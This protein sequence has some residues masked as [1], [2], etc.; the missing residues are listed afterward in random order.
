MND[1]IEKA[2]ELIKKSQFTIA[3][4]GAGISV[5]SGIPDFR[6]AG[7]LWEKYDPALYASIDSFKRKP[8][9]VW[10]MLFEMVD[11]MENAKPNPAHLALA[12]LEQLGYLSSIITQNI[13]NLH[14]AAGSKHVI[15][16]HGNA[17]RLECLSCG[18]VYEKPE[19]MPENV[20]IPRCAACDAV[21]K[22]TVI[23]FGEMIPY[24]AMSESSRL[25]DRAELVLVVGT[26]AIVYPAAGIPLQAKQNNATVIE[27][28]LEPTALTGYI[29]DLFIQGPAGETLNRVL[30]MLEKG[31][32]SA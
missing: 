14:Q 18:R 26:S 13:D 1:Q 16:Y 15:E 31:T 23:F 2:V 7:G 32:P 11:I 27:F 20:A 24:E 12:R 30:E 4:T 3:L 28:N 5:E 10:D 6:S 22:P 9:M 25:A 21:L 8:E 29:T 17:S 19:I